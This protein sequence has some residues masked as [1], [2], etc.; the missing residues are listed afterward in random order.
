MKKL[1]AVTS[2]TLIS[3][4]SLTACGASGDVPDGRYYANDGSG[5]YIESSNN[6]EQCALHVGFENADS[7][8]KPSYDY[9]CVFDKKNKEVTTPSL[10]T[11]APYEVKGDDLI[12][13]A[14]D[15]SSEAE[16]YTREG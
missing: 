16:V 9:T 14:N 7:L 5:S 15:D 12:I 2:L 4:A 13:G 6:G 3:A 11:S 10:S 8:I 1:L